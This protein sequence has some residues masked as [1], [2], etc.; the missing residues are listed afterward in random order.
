MANNYGK[1]NEVLGAL[2]TGQQAPPQ[3]GLAKFSQLVSGFLEKY[4]DF[5]DPINI[6]GILPSKVHNMTQIWYHRY[7]LNPKYG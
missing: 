5:V 4:G 6:V 7:G 1:K 3:L 2:H